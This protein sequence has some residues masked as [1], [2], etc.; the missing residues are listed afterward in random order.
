M[1]TNF[2]FLIIIVLSIALLWAFTAI[3]RIQK[4]NNRRHEEFLGV[5]NGVNEGVL[6]SDANG[7]VLTANRIFEDLVGQ[8]DLK[9]KSYTDLNRDKQIRSIIQETLEKKAGL[10][11]EISFEDKVYFCKSLYLDQTDEVLFVMRDISEFKNLETIKR[12]L[13]ANVSHEL[14]TPLTAIKG[15]IE[16]IQDEFKGENKKYLDIIER[17]T[18]RLIFIVQ[19][20]LILSRL[21]DQSIEPDYQPCD[22]M[23]LI[24]DTG[25]LLEKK[26]RQKGIQLRILDG[27]KM[28]IEGD[29]NQLVQLFVN[30]IDNAIKYTEKGEVSVEVRPQKSSAIIVIKDTGIG[31]EKKHLSRIFER[32]Y[33][34]DSSRSRAQGGTGLGLSI[35]KHIV[36]AHK[37]KVD[38]ESFPQKGTSV[39]IELPFF[40]NKTD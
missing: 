37:G 13:I 33:V 38:I 16:T 29:R 20:L 26:A 5:L 9:G 18:D 23:Q 39:Y 40:Q 15:F 28:Q 17:N 8:K 25:L 31:M 21:E 4:K 32:F 35:V 12:T 24:S 1:L 7:L 10:K 36:S 22:L 34:V 27:Q 3:L 6:L 11:K 14:R 2:L 19:D 30:L